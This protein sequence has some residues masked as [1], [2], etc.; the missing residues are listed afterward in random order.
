M[1]RN[2]TLLVCDDI[3]VE[4]NGKLIVIGLYPG[5]VIVP[6]PD[7]V[8]SQLL[9]LF[10]IDTDIKDRPAIVEL[11]IALPGEEPVTG[12]I[13]MVHGEVQPEYTRWHIRQVLAISN[14]PLRPGKIVATATLDGEPHPVS[15]AWIEVAPTV[16]PS[17][18]PTA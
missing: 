15:S 18:N 1:P 8:C 3:R 9:F 10:N 6:T 7:Y 5:N 16:A 2:V 14:S 4:G 11:S 17:E 12:T 13:Q